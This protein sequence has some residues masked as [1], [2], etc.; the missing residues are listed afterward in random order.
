MPLTD[1][2]VAVRTQVLTATNRDDTLQAASRLLAC[3]HA[4]AEE[5]HR[6]LCQREDLGSTAIGHGVAIPHGRCNAYDHARA[7]FLRLV[8]PVDF[9]A[10][11]HQAV[12]LVFAMAVPEHFTQEHLQWLAELAERF[13]DPDFRGSLR[14]ADSLDELRTLMLS[15]P[16]AA[17]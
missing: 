6:S 3:D 13:A 7:A 8:K 12:D 14:D 10:S 15:K 1:L 4:G 11:D 5:I 2:L 16:A 17:A 9:G